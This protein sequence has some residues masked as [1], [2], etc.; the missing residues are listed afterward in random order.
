MKGLA[1]NP[2]WG[3]IAYR[4]ALDNHVPARR[5]TTVAEMQRMVAYR[6]ADETAPVNWLI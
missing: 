1:R 3:G 2:A 4:V 6:R 5:A